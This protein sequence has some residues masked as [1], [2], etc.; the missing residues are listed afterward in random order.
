MVEKGVKALMAEANAAIETISVQEALPLHGRDDVVFVDVREGEE[1]ARGHIPGSVHAPRSA[2]EF[3]FD[4]GSPSHNPALSSGKRLVLYCAAG[5]RS[6]LS[7]K[8]L[9]DMGVANVCH[10]AGGISGWT[11]A[12]GPVEK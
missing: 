2:L 9:A 3:V 10:V 5:G 1:F 8:T 12:G 11:E 7:A 6:A 4:P